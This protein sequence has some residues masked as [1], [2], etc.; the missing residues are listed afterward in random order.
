MLKRESEVAKL[1]INLFLMIVKENIDFVSDNFQTLSIDRMY[2]NNSKFFTSRL[3][4][5]S[6]LG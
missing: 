5:R 1:Y 2:E 3:N 6:K 4:F